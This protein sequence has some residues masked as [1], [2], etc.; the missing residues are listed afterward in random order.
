MKTIIAGSRHLNSIN[1]VIEAV[2][3]SKFKI[4]E[5]ICGEARG[6]DTQGKNW[7]F[8]HDIPVKSFPADW[9]KYGKR[10]GYLRNEEM[11][12]YGEALILIWDGESKGSEHMLNLAKKYDLK[13][14][15]LIIKKDGK[16]EWFHF[17]K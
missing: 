8:I 11:A 4:A 9:E 13:I 5:V 17:T 14:F 2:N 3:L 1:H 7:A 15:V 10:A 6:P 12:K 16:K